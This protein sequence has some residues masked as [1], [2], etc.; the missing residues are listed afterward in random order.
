MCYLG[1][2]AGVGIH[3]T[4]SGMLLDG[5]DPESVPRQKRYGQSASQ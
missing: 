3:A 4:G 2:P 1:A 5:A